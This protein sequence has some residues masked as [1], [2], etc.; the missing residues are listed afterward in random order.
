MKVSVERY[1]PAVVLSCRGE[2]TGDSLE[3]FRAAATGAVGDGEVRDVV[4]D[5]REV[6]FVDS[7][8]LEYLLELQEALSERLGQ[9]KLTAADANVAKILEITRLENAFESYPDVTE[10][11][12]AV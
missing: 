12:R 7:A 11:V 3:A 1:G 10:A 4:V 6:P 9:V 2:L 5:L 8:G